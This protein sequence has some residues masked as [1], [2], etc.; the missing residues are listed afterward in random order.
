M[1]SF[2][3][4]CVV[5]HT[6]SLTNFIALNKKVKIDTN[7]INFLHTHQKLNSPSKFSI[8][9]IICSPVYFRLRQ[10]RVRKSVNQTGIS[11][12]FRGNPPLRLKYLIFMENFQR[13]RKHWQIEPP[14]VNLNPLSRHP[15]SAPGY[16]GCIIWTNIERCIAKGRIK[17]WGMHLTGGERP[18]S[19]LF[20]LQALK[21]L[22]G[23]SF[24]GWFAPLTAAGEK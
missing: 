8:K 21:S 24:L 18:W 15:G 20:F 10:C 17:G 12:R 3:Y 14:F 7:L 16:S 19:D 5:Y 13:I 6:P 23:E 4:W 11:G 1:C 2:E 9:K 22:D